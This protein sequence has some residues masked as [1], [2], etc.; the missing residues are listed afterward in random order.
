MPTMGVTIIVDSREEGG[1]TFG[2]P[3][4]E[5]GVSEIEVLT[6]GDQKVGK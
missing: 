5:E 6:D 3:D 2:L 1:P 4:V